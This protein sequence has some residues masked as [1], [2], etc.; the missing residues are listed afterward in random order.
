MTDGYHLWK[1]LNDNC[2]LD[3]FDI[4]GDGD[5]FPKDPRL[6]T[7]NILADNLN[8]KKAEEVYREWHERT[9]HRGMYSNWH[10]LSGEE[11]DEWEYLVNR[12][13]KFVRDWEKS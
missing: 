4:N 2:L 11:K 10:D 7:W 13:R 12:M 1:F 9:W 5:R 3:K 6:A 8:S